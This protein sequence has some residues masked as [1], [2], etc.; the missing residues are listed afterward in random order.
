MAAPRH[1]LGAAPP[2]RALMLGRA[3]PRPLFAGPRQD[4]QARTHRAACNTPKQVSI[5]VA[6]L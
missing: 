5:A 4:R 3:F 2:H 1:R 6:S